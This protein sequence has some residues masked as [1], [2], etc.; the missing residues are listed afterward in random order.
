MRYVDVRR[1]RLGSQAYCEVSEQA[2]IALRPS[3]TI[4]IT[5]QR[6]QDLEEWSNTVLLTDFTS[7][8]CSSH[9]FYLGDMNLRRALCRFFPSLSSYPARRTKMVVCYINY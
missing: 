4:S 3:N 1:L 5:G 7:L 2:R 6:R 9:T 8:F